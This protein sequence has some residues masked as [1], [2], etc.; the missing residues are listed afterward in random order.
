MLEAIC[1]TFLWIGQ[2]ELSKKEQIAWEKICQSSSTGGLEVIDLK[3]WNKADILK[4]LW[5]FS[6]KDYVD[7]IGASLLC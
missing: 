6:K 1:R 7:Q 4:H 3:L 2:G 5:D